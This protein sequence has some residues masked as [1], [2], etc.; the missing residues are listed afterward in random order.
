MEKATN[1]YTGRESCNQK[2]DVLRTNFSMYLFLLLNRSFF[3]SHETLLIL[4]QA[5]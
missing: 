5:R 4:Q 1:N 3:S 2:S